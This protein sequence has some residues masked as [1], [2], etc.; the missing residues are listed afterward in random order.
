MS[1]T[2]WKKIQAF[3]GVTSDGIPG[4]ITAGAIADRL[5]IGTP[6]PAPKSTKSPE[7]D[8]RSEKNLATLVS[9]TERKA[10][11][12]LR[13]C[14]E[15]GI[16]VKIIC[17][18]R[19]YEEQ[20]ALYAKGR[21]KP[22]SKVTNARPGFSWHNFG[23]AWDFVVFDPKG[24]PLWDSPLMARCGKI[25]E[26]LGLEWGGSWKSFKDKPHLQLKT[27][28]SLA[29]ARQRVKDGKRIA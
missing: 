20:A 11:Q 21:T 9:N 8:S 23:V 16:N 22:G 3:V 2:L 12:W 27:G 24:Q 1:K 29:E 28:I 14:R 4:P 18:T 19:S 5:G 26:E 6:K 17:G 7:F 25:G 15:A 13:T 10:R